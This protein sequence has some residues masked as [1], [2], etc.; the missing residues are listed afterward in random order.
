[1]SLLLT[2]KLK[3]S[4]CEEFESQNI[5]NNLADISHINCQYKVKISNAVTVAYCVL[6]YDCCYYGNE[7]VAMVI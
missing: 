5:E 1:M 3:K 7:M 2:R 4:S 6:F